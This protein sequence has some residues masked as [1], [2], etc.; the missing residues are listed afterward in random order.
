MKT[1]FGAALGPA[2]RGD[3]GGFASELKRAHYYT[4]S[5]ADYARGLTSLMGAASGGVA[6]PPAPA[7]ATSSTFAATSL[8]LSH[9]TLTRVSDAL[10]AERF[11]GLSSVSLGGSPAHSRRVSDDEED[12]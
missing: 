4:A 11:G 1:Q 8:G 6:S 10:D 9:A 12:S 2:S 7:S 3:V 5:E